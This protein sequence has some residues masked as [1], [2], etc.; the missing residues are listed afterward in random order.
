MHLKYMTSGICEEGAD[1]HQI[2]AVNVPH[3]ERC[4]GE[5]LTYRN[6]HRSFHALLTM[7]L[8][9]HLGSCPLLETTQP[10]CKDSKPP[11]N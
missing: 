4:P 6:R 3:T 1:V 11:Q 5:V 8:Y 9:M 10:M 2:W 7:D